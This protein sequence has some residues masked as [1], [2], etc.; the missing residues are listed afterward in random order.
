MPREIWEKIRKNTKYFSFFFAKIIFFEPQIY[1]F[2]N[3][4]P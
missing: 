3:K 2:M 4:L 1:L